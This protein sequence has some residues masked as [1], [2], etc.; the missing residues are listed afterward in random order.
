R[1]FIPLMLDKAEVKGPLA[2][3]LYIDWSLDD[4]SQIYSRLLDACRSTEEGTSTVDD[5][6]I[7]KKIQLDCKATVLSY[8]FKSNGKLA[9]SGA[10]DKTVRLWDLETGS[11]VHVFKDHAAQVRQVAWSTDEQYALSGANDKTVRQWDI[12]RGACMQ[13]LEGHKG[14]V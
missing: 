6:F 12:W 9:L 8:A 2:Q 14:M 11:C 10:N 13:V 5:E 1:R 7:E 3:L 4:Q